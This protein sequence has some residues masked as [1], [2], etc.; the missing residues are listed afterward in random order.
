MTGA[1]QT[2]LRLLKIN[3]FS[4]IAVFEKTNEKKKKKKYIDE[5]HN[6]AMFS[7]FEIESRPKKYSIRP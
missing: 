6:I 2:I 5:E 3:L 4:L 1:G 7:R